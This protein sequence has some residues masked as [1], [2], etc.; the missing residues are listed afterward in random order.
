MTILFYSYLLIFFII[1]HIKYERFNNNETIMLY[2]QC[3]K[4]VFC[5]HKNRSRSEK[6]SKG[7]RILLFTITNNNNNNFI[8]TITYYH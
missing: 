1:N 6:K 7:D 3:W 8:A 2:R 4:L 5:C